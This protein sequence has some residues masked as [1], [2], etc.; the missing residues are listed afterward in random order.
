[1]AVRSGAG[2][3]VTVALVVFVVTTVCL[4]VMTIIFY[5]GRSEALQLKDESEQALAD[6]VTDQQRNRDLFK[7]YES[8]AEQQRQSVAGYL[9]DQYQSTLAFVDP[10]VPTL[11]QLKEKAQ[12]MGV[13]G[14]Q[15]LMRAL[16][17]TRSELRRKTGEIEGLQQQLQQR[18]DR[19]ADLQ[20]QLEQTK[21]A[22]QQELN[23]VQGQIGEY[24]RAAEDY[25]NELQDTMDRMEQAIAQQKQQYEQRVNDLET[26]VD[27]LHQE[28]AVL[29]AR[30]D[31]LEEKISEE[32]IQGKDPALLVDGRIIDLA[33]AE[34]EIYIDRG[35]EDRIVLGMTFEV[36]DNEAALAAITQDS[37]LPRGKASIQVT[38][39]GETTSTCKVTRSIPGRPVVRGDVIA[40]AVYDPDYKFKFLV[41]GKFDTNGDGRPT[42]SEAE[43]L[44]SVV[45]DWGGTVVTG[46]QIPGDLDFLVLGAQPPMP[47]P[48]PSDAS[49]AMTRDWVRKR[50][51]VEQYNAMF[52]QAREAQIP[53]LNANRFMILTGYTNR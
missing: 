27:D 2:T 14:N 51:I 35:R 28:R 1:M 50:E 23:A 36:Y 5:A 8:R 24:R 41:H 49:A 52:R 20:D 37:R 7:T 12:T 47:P 25:R 15:P 3:G 48:L 34:D 19:I 33:G 46:N 53:V 22:H 29:R 45:V 42:E 26:E 9:N 16:Q 30:I 39:V 31:D 38:K 40:N 18:E 32:R 11:E 6:Y 44:R 10:A 21:Q 43:F 17:D 13:P 4:L